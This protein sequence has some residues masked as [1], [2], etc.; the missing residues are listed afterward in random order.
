VGDIVGLLIGAVVR[1]TSAARLGFVVNTSDDVVVGARLAAAD[2]DA[3]GFYRPG[4]AGRRGHARRLH[5]R[6]LNR[7]SG[8]GRYCRVDDR[9]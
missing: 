6:T 7:G 3:V 9:L 8:R 4:S 5:R 2:G 1:T